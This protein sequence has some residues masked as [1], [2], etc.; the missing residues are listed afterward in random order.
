[1]LQSRELRRLFLPAC[2]KAVVVVKD[3]D[4][5]KKFLNSKASRYEQN[6]YFPCHPN[7][8]LYHYPNSIL[9]GVPKILRCGNLSKNWAKDP[10]DNMELQ[11]SR[12][13]LP[14][15]ISRCDQQFRKKGQN[16]V[17]CTEPKGR[18][19]AYSANLERL[20]RRFIEFVPFETIGCH[21]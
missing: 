8:G 15:R 17:L 14:S 5:Q 16:E 20:S 13:L 18:I 3:W 9:N 4:F 6:Y 12:F 19:S 7:S 11:V 2:S 10:G 1:M 21:H